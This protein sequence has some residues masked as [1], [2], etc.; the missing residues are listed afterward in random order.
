MKITHKKALLWRPKNGSDLEHDKK[1][2]L[3]YM[4]KHCCGKNNARKIDFVLDEIRPKLRKRDYKRGGFQ[5]SIVVPFKEEKEFYI[6]TDANK[7]IFFVV[8]E[9]DVV[10]TLNF[11]R[12]RIRAEH[13][14]LRNLKAIAKKYKLLKNLTTKNDNKGKKRI[15]LDESGTPVIND[16]EPYFIVGAL[17]VN[18]EDIKKLN[19][20]FVAINNKLGYPPEGELSSRRIDSRNY[21]FILNKLAKID[22]E[23]AA[24]CFVKKYLTSNGY[25]Y[26]KSFYKQAYQFLVGDILDYIGEASL[27]FDEY[28][29]KGARFEKEFFNY[30]KKE[31][32]GFVLNKIKK[33]SS[34]VSGQNKAVQF[35]DLLIGAV[36]YKLKRKFD[37]TPWFEEKIISV[38]YFPHL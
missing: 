15:F 37:V 36:K 10:C 35:V 25:Q 34:E 28:G 2:F 27:H 5:Q 16:R 17:I 11:Y 32:F 7:G 6:G 21:K 30:L 38:Q 8:N 23:F 19:E 33:I 29:T 24:I 26:P 22:Y 14:H 4:I 12:S 18:N 1:V 20:L 9:E 31:N 13:K 3:D